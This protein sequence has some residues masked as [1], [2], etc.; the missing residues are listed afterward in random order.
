[1]T[2]KKDALCPICGQNFR[3]SSAMSSA[4]VCYFW[5]VCAICMSA[6]IQHST[7]TDRHPEHRAFGSVYEMHGY[8][9][10]TSLQHT[11][12]VHTSDLAA[13]HGTQLFEWLLRTL[14]LHHHRVPTG[15]HYLRPSSMILIQA[16]RRTTELSQAPLWA[17][18]WR[19]RTT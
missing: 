8:L 2:N 18:A 5:D 4:V 1:M 10:R 13:A 14:L 16:M 11:P 15:Q 6:T 9:R 7:G 17:V 3:L 12:P 19:S